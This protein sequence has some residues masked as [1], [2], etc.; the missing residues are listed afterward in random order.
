M[1]SDKVSLASQWLR[2]KLPEIPKALRSVRQLPV[3]ASWHCTLPRNT[4]NDEAKSLKRRL[5]EKVEARYRYCYNVHDS[6]ATSGKLWFDSWYR[7]QICLISKASTTA[8]VPKQ[9]TVRSATGRSFPG[10]KT[11][12]VWSWQLTPSST[13]IRNMWSYVSTSSYAFMVSTR[14]TLLLNL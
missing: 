12:W 14:T 1:R 7:Q 6:G 13:E 9:P 8:L 3:T 5:Y 2:A 11:A 4:A 10:I